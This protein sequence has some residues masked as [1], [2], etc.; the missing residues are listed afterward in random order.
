M[1]L[2][3]TIYLD[4]E[5]SNLFYLTEIEWLDG[6]DIDNIYYGY[7]GGTA[8]YGFGDC[9]Y[10]KTSLTN[11]VNI[12]GTPTQT[13]RK[14][15]PK[16]VYVDYNNTNYNR[17]GSQANPLNSIYEAVNCFYPFRNTGTIIVSDVDND[18]THPIYLEKLENVN[19]QFNEI[20]QF[21]KLGALNCNNVTV[22]ACNISA[23]N[24]DYALEVSASNINLIGINALNNDL[25]MNISINSKVY[26]NNRRQKDTNLENSVI[27][28]EIEF[29]P[30]LV[31]TSIDNL[32]TKNGRIKGLWYNIPSANSAHFTIPFCVDQHLSFNLYANDINQ[33]ITIPLIPNKNIIETVYRLGNHFLVNVSL[34]TDAD[35]NQYTV[36]VTAEAYNSS[37]VSIPC[38]ITLSQLIP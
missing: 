10:A 21:G 28:G 19:L 5:I 25:Y 22:F 31:A 3:Q 33:N 38:T 7:I 24:D 36:D 1:N 9:G 29:F 23:L 26:F 34:T 15:A 6:T 32:N 12:A 8:N 30:R 35:N 18:N 13:I 17:N 4:P 27:N 14:G 2:V 16:L 37:N 20:F 11:K